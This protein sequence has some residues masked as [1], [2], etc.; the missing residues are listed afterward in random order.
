MYDT[1]LV[2]YFTGI[3]SEVVLRKGP[4]DW[5]I[6]ENYIVAEIQKWILHHGLKDQ[7]FYFRTN[8]G[9]EV[10]LIIENLTKNI[11]LL[12]EIKSTETPRPEMFSHILKVEELES[13]RQRRKKQNDNILIYRGDTVLDYREGC[14]CIN[15]LD[16]DSMLQ[17]M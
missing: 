14:Q 17:K 1:G 12:I 13:K 5:P 7:L 10:D 8:L 11:L 16:L 6:F 4:L 3:E 9:I 15:Y 2:C